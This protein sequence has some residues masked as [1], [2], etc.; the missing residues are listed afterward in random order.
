[1]F[2]IKSN[3]DE[4][5][6]IILFLDEINTNQ[7]INGVLKELFID[8]KIKGEPLPKNFEIIAAANPY[9]FKSKEE[10][11]DNQDSLKIAGCENAQTSK[12][13]YH[14]NPLAESMYVSIFEFGEL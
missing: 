1:M 2:D 6:K 13:V 8:K 11:K 3:S 9:K 7:N 14:V 4:N 10:M 12:L 5:S